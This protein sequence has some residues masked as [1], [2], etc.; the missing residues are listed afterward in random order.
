[1]FE[2]MESSV[3]GMARLLLCFL[4]VFVSICVQRGMQDQRTARTE[5]WLL[6]TL[7]FSLSDE[8]EDPE[9][10]S[11]SLAGSNSQHSPPSSQNN[12]GSGDLADEAAMSAH[13]NELASLRQ[14]LALERA[15]HRKEREEE[16]A[17][18]RKEQEEERARYRSYRKEQEEERRKAREEKRRMEAVI[19]E[20]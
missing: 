18:H 16:R 15:Q 12:S 2:R 14:Q 4:L 7:D 1:M 20:K 3:F 11:R 13:F 5:G 9:S 8:D 19:E 10:Q 17:Q 6:G